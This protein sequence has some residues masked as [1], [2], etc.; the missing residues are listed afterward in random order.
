MIHHHCPGPIERL[1]QLSRIGV[2]GR[3]IRTHG[4][5]HLGQTLWSGNDWVILDFEGEPARTLVEPQR[6]PKSATAVARAGQTPPTTA[7]STTARR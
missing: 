7:T 5:Y 3:V 2:G 1:G 4:D 6:R